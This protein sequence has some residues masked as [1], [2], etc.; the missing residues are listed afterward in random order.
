MKIKTALSFCI[1]L[2]AIISL[3]LVSYLYFST[4]KIAVVRSMDLIYQYNGMK[5][6]KA[7]FKNQTDGWKSNLDTLQ[8]KYQTAL[9]EYQSK[10]ASYNESQR[11][12]QEKMLGVMKNNLEKYAKVVNTEASNQEQEKT[13]A[14]LNQINSQIQDYAKRN[15]IDVVLGADGSGAILFGSEHFDITENVLKELNENYKI[16]PQAK[17]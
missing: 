8:I 6:A 9:S 15:N 13:Q 14:V 4:P 17:L 1:S 12:E 3:L 10:Y 5:D 2:S 7:Q 16:Q 11:Q